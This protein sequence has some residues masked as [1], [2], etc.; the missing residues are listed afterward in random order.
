MD[1]QYLNIFI[2]LHGIALIK[3]SG[4]YYE[5]DRIKVIFNL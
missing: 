1:K 2:D 5:R 3:T 4:I